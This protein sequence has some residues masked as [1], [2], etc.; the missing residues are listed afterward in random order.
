MLRHQHRGIVAHRIKLA[1][2]KRLER[3]QRPHALVA[4]E[5]QH[6][7]R[8]QRNAIA[9]QKLLKIGEDNLRQIMDL[10]IN[11]TPTPSPG[12]SD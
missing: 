5:D 1:Q 10:L 3:N 2:A 11:Q 12:R 4:G 6:L 8:I 9:L 7:H